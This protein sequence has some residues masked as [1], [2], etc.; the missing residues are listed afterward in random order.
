MSGSYCLYT[1]YIMSSTSSGTSVKPELHVYQR[2]LLKLR[3]MLDEQK[4]QPGQFLA[5]EYDLARR[6]G[7]SRRSVRHAVDILVR[8]GR[9]ERRS[10]KGLYIRQPGSVTRWVQVV[11][12]TLAAHLCI[13]MA[14]GIKSAALKAGVQIQI[15]DAHGSFDSDLEALR[16]LPATAARGAII[17]SLHHKRFAEV[18]YELKAARYPF[19][20]VD[21]SLRDIEVPTVLADN[22]RG[23]YLVGRELIQRGHC[24]IGYISFPADTT[25]LRAQGLQDALIDSKL[26]FDRSLN[27]ELRMTLMEDSSAEIDRLTRELLHLPH[28]PT[29]IFYNNDHAAIRGYEAIHALGLRIPEDVS[30]VGFDGDPSCRL[31]TPSLATIRQPAR[32][33]GIAAMEILLDLMANSKGSADNMVGDDDLP[34]QVLA[35]TW[36]EGGS[37]GPAPRRRPINHSTRQLQ[38]KLR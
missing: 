12:P 22:Y 3:Q 7:V 34:H 9:V 35:I 10:G 31:L 1:L 26:P 30:V 32:E 23:G 11:V 13:E 38:K 33:M 24:G 20:L 8:E 17:W 29:A 25:R 4:M 2:L 19:V 28:P 21:E 15:Y 18:L 5:S 27:R 36:Q 6:E 37:I 14:G 16:Q